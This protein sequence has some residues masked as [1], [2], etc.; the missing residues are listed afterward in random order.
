[1][2]P[3]DDVTSARADVTRHDPEVAAGTLAEATVGVASDPPEPAPR[4]S[5]LRFALILGGLTAFG[6]L[7]VDMYLPA[8]PQLTTALG[9]SSA[10]AQ[11]T[12]T[13]VLLGLAFGQ[14]IAGPVSDAVG[15]RGPLLVGVSLYTVVS[16]LCAV[17]VSVEQL[18][19]LR[20]VQGLSA[21]A[22]MVIA[23][24]AIRDLYSGA[25]ATRFFSALMLV[26]GLAPILAPVIGGGVLTYTTWRGVFVVLAGFGALLLAVVAFALPE[27]KPQR[28][29]QPL[30]WRATARTFGM[31]LRTRS[32]LGNAL[33]AGFGI[34]VMFAYVSGSSYVLQ[35]VYGMSPQAFA[36]TFGLNS[37]GLV[38]CGQ[39]NGL[40]AGRV[41]TEQQLLG[42]A[43]IAATV[44]GAVLVT[45]VAAGLPL[46]AV[47][48]AMFV[49]ISCMGFVMPNAAMLALADHREVSGSASALLG[50]CQFVIGA[51]A[52]PL[53]G[54]GG[55]ES[56]LPM[57]L[58]MF[59]VALAATVTWWA[60]G[61]RRHTPA[62]VTVARGPG[63][64]AV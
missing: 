30:K 40:L 12:L 32:F 45:T 6:P 8:L 21:A 31:L 44:S 13:T 36:L 48:A 42:R 16:V 53:V 24:A 56:A 38:A 7:S 33:A 58:V 49:L 54:L 14:L 1:M 63:R 50:A 34:A 62:P 5:K 26:T 28:W 47:L 64:D 23:R 25:E 10:Q 19:V 11:L 17:A 22:G 51:L 15:R 41:A 55:V 20:L 35:D 37:V 3:G 60:L 52:A 57:A 59:G 29:R 9:T 61:R 46:V 2:P 18:T 4:G 39:I 43:L 27:T